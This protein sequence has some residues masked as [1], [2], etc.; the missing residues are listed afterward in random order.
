MN[1]FYVLRE[2]IF[3]SNINNRP[4][5]CFNDRNVKGKYIKLIDNNFISFSQA[6]EWTKYSTL[7]PLIED[8]IGRLFIPY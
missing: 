4:I 5:S 3:P 8:G 1:Y 7:Y 2:E 6:L